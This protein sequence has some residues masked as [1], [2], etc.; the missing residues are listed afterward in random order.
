[1]KSVTLPDPDDAGVLLSPVYSYEYDLVGNVT[2]ST[3]P[4]GRF[5]TTIYDALYRPRSRILLA[6]R[7][8]PR[9]ILIARTT[10]QQSLDIN[11][12]I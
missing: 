2:K 12:E 9:F 6:N 1:M 8:F 4:L 11:G 7:W 3:D 5:T 10:R